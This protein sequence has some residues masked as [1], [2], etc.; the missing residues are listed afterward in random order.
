[1]LGP[2]DFWPSPLVANIIW[3]NVL[4]PCQFMEISPAPPQ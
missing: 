1:M 3:E 2:E 4:Y